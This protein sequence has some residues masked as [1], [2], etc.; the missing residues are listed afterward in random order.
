MVRQEGDGATIQ[1]CQE[2]NYENPV[3][4]LLGEIDKAAKVLSSTGIQAVDGDHVLARSSDE[5]RKL[6]T[7]RLEEDEVHITAR[8]W[9]Q[10][11]WTNAP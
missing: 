1:S 8:C 6:E 2:E 5:K 11:S 3:S 7:Y 9:H 4:R 10:V